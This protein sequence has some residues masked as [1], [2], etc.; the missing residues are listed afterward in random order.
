MLDRDQWAPPE[1]GRG[2]DLTRRATRRSALALILLAAGERMPAAEAGDP[3]TGVVYVQSNDPNGKRTLEAAWEQKLAALRDLSDEH[4]RFLREQPRALSGDGRAEIRRLAADLPALWSAPSTTDA[5]RK[6]VLR[7]V[8]EEVVVAVEGETE[9]CGARVRWAGGGETLTRLHRPVA[10]LEQLADRERLRRRIVELK[11]EGLTA[12]RIA[13]RLDS[14]GLR[15]AGGGPITPAVVARLVRRYGLARERPDEVVVGRGE[16][17]VPD[18]AR[19]LGV[20]P[21]TVYSWARRGVVGSRRIGD[22]GHGRLVITGLGDRPDPGS[23]RQHMSAV[24]VGNG[25]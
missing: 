22:G 25:R 7:Q 14:E 20:P 11:G 12:P 24:E 10:S 1:C 19:R 23:I 15:A 17:L 4:E 16:S 2:R 13:E 9:W 21:A 5:D 3:P 6:E 8:V 18:L